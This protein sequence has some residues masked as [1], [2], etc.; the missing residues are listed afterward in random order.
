MPIKFPCVFCRK[1]VKSNQN[2]MRCVCCDKW[3]HLKCSRM[4]LEFFKSNA[5]W[6]CDNC[7]WGE[8]PSSE[9]LDVP[10]VATDRGGGEPLVKNT[11]C[12]PIQCTLERTSSNSAAHERIEQNGS[13]IKDMKGFKITHLNCVSLLKYFDEIKQFIC[14]TNIDILTL[15]ETHLS[16]EID[17]G[18]IAVPGYCL[19]RR[20]R[21]R[22]GG[23]LATYIKNDI[24]FVSR[25]DLNQYDNLE[26]T[27]IEIKPTKSKP[28]L[29]IN[30]YRP[31]NSNVEVFN[32]FETVVSNIDALNLHYFIL[33][34]MNCDTLC[35]RRSWQTTKL[36]DIM[37]SYN[38]KQLITQYTRVTATTSTAVDLIFTNCPD[39]CSS[40]GI[41]EISLSDHYM[42]YCVIGKT[43]SVPQN[44]H[45]YKCN[46][47]F[48]RFSPQSYISDIGDICWNSVY[49]SKNPQSAY[50][51][52]ISL[53]TEVIDKH[54]PMHKRRVKTKESPWMT[55]DILTSIRTRDRLKAK[56]KKTKSTHDWESYKKARNDVTFAVRKAK[57]DFI[58]KK[59][60]STK[61]SSKEI[62][63][64]LKYLTPNKKNS[65][66][67]NNVTIDN[68][69]TRGK[70]LAN[71]FNDFFVNIGLS[72][73]NESKKTN[74]NN[75]LKK[76]ESIF[77]FNTVSVTDV[78]K[79]LINLP[80]D[81][82]TGPDGVPAKVLP[83]IA[84]LIASPLTH[85]INRS[86][87]EGTIP[88]QW[89]IARVTPIFKGGDNNILGNYRPISVIS[90]IGKIMERIAYNQVL[91]YLLENNILTNCQSGFRPKFSTQTALLNVTDN[92]L[93]AMDRGDLV[94]VVMIDLKKAFDTVDHAI[95]L[96]KLKMYGFNDRAVK[97]FENYLCNQRQQFTC[98]N[99]I[100][101]SVKNVTCGVP[102]GSL[103]GPLLFLLYT[104]DM[105][106]K[107][108]YCKLAL[109]ADDTC[110]FFSNKDPNLIYERI[111]Y[112]L[113]I[114]SE[115]LNAN[116]L[117]INA[118][119]CET[120]IIGTKQKLK[121]WKN[122]IDDNQVYIDNT[123]VTKVK[124]C[125]YLGIY[126]DENL[127]WNRQT[128]FLKSKVVKNVYLLKRIRPFITEQTASLF[129]KSV[130]QAHF[131]YCSV[132]WGNT[133]KTN[134]DKLQIL[135][136]RALR[137]VLKVK[138]LF[139][140]NSLYSVLKLDRLHVRRSK[141]FAQVMYQC[142]HHIGPPYLNELF[143]LRQSHYSTRSG[144]SQLNMTRP[145]TDYGKR[146]FAYQG[147]LLWNSLV[148]NT[149]PNISLD[150]FKKHLHNLIR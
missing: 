25:H 132:V 33:G 106:D 122:L 150:T 9:C 1:S 114:I 113:E 36:F 46:R 63:K 92:W 99:G 60:N 14:H 58:T 84:H 11:V 39:K 30:W 47:D 104:N 129:F 141:H 131:D 75:N 130:I 56:A 67:I 44:Y 31:P 55:K 93:S 73:Q 123:P 119:K 137:A 42:I 43:S 18:E 7:T 97:W 34:D 127:S 16:S 76:V 124:A 54:A 91:Q 29:V 138:N 2:A 147:A 82:A 48:K 68:V 19:V 125:K 17:D 8:L 20:D 6:I 23:G 102:Q 118:K 66:P 85:I 89:K 139:P 115:W 3:G 88:Y 108:R 27:I 96:H 69:P 41:I 35:S 37:D 94:G 45:K 120:M 52:F 15:S 128:E 32:N 95:L 101:S 61:D 77:S 135:Q 26:M 111:N 103:L 21:N 136:N 50:D 110:L 70:E 10:N 24:N 53:L 38:C 146:R 143:T 145:K 13:K 142:V 22:H 5:D 28:F 74:S 100:S 112:D 107:V 105:P 98:I 80:C 133:N 116:K 59:I 4:S 40:S 90:V 126:I 140:T 109:Y 83:S 12:A 117:V 78:M 86:L 87:Y 64:S 65:S 51:T 71:A 134:L 148:R 79:L 72:V 121:K 81:K 149:P 57:R 49:E 144:D 62:W